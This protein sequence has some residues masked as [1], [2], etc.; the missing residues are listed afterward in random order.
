MDREKTFNE[1]CDEN[2]EL[3]RQYDFTRNMLQIMLASELTRQQ[4]GV[5][6]EPRNRRLK[7]DP[8]NLMRSYKRIEEMRKKIGR[9]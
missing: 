8:E 2:L 3:I 5:N 9:E 1:V 7:E 4:L 6:P